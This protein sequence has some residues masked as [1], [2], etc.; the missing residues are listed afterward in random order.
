MYLFFRTPCYL[1]QPTHEQRGFIAQLLEALHS[2][3]S[4]FFIEKCWLISSNSIYTYINRADYLNNFF[5]S[6][7]IFWNGVHYNWIVWMLGEIRKEGGQWKL[8]G[9]I[10]K[11]S[12]VW[13]QESCYLSQTVPVS[14]SLQPHFPPEH[15]W[16]SHHQLQQEEGKGQGLPTRYDFKNNV[17]VLNSPMWG[18]PPSCMKQ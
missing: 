16:A 4:R 12:C 14:W 6:I 13:D 3:H 7:I 8:V 5:K 1:N 2:W 17:G 18:F 11:F 9:C 10:I 15:P